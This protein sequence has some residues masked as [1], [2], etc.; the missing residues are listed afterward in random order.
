MGLQ[1][2]HARQ[3][4][5][6]RGWARRSERGRTV[7]EEG[8]ALCQALAPGA[9]IGPLIEWTYLVIEAE[10]DLHVDLNMGDLGTLDVAA[11]L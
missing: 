3:S 6:W 1:G 5:S 4:S 2:D 8:P 11:H 10:T 9:Q 7:E